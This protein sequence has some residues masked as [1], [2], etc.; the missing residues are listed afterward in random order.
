ML[1]WLVFLTLTG[2]EQG[3]SYLKPI[4]PDTALDLVNYFD[5]T[6]INSTFKRINCTQNN[7]KFRKVQPR[8]SPSVW[9]VHEVS[10]SDEH[11][12]NNSTKGWNNRFSN[13][14]GHNHPYLWTLIKKLD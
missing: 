6:Y 10:L 9:N 1:R 8:F 11:R 2:V 4:M 14:V 13:L 3:I 5:Y 12:T 7:I